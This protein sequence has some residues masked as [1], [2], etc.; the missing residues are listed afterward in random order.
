MQFFSKDAFKFKQQLKNIRSVQSICLCGLFVASYVALSMFNIR[1]SEFLEFRI[2]FLSLALAGFYGGPV[3]GM[4]VGIA[5][6]VVSF[7]VVP[8]SAPF[9]PGF[10]L[11]YAILGFL[12]GM[13]LYRSRITPGRALLAGLAEFT[14]SCTLT[15]LWLHLMYGMAWKYLFTIRLA[16]NSISLVVYTILLFI[17]LKAFSRVI[18]S[19]HLPAKAAQP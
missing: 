8:Q 12:F 18:S 11:T 9:F 2:A 19:A 14:V 4:S 10:T 13:I 6:D 5:G 16:K 3:M 15:T 17:F 1:F 7:F